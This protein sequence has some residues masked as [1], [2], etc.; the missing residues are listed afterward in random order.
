MGQMQ[1]EVR[2]MAREATSS[3]QQ[4]RHERKSA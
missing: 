4:Q 3:Q 1:G 2:E